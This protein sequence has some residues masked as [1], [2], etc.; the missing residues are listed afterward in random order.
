MAAIV[1]MGKP[2]KLEP[3]LFYHNISLEQRI[4][5]GH[6]LRKIEKLVNFSFI[7][8]KVANLY[9]TN[10]NNSIDPTVILKL[11]LLAFYENV[12]SERALMRQFPMRMD[13]LWFCGYDLDDTT[14][15]H[16][17]ISKARSRWGID[18]FSDF[19]E[20][21]LNQCI[22]TGLVDGQTVHIDSSMID[23]NAS[24]DS[25][26]CQLRKVSNELYNELQTVFAIE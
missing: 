25:L 18:V 3:K 14:P 21:I 12:K 1:M 13:W 15:D 16:S 19:F 17:V 23:A 4:P 6:P 8:S 5:K 11:M 7:H 20:N 10:G 2:N 22:D 26:K 9:G 24:M